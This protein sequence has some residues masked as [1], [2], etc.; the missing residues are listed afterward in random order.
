[1]NSDTDAAAELIIRTALDQDLPELQQVFREASLSNEGDAPALLAHPEYLIFTGDGIAEGRTRVIVTTVGNSQRLVGFATLARGPDGQPDVEDLFVHPQWRRRGI[2]RRLIHDLASTARREGH[3]TV[4]VI[5][6]QHAL[7][8][9]Q[10]VGFVEFGSAETAL[11]LAPHLRL[12][13]T[14]QNRAPMEVPDGARSFLASGQAYDAFMGRYSRPLAI[15]FADAVGVTAG[16][17]ALDV[18][19]GPGAL[20]GVLVDRLGPGAVSAFDPSPSFVT[21]CARRHPGVTV[22]PGRAEAMPFDEGRFDCALAQ[23]VLHFVSDPGQAAH[24]FCRVLRP[25]GLAAACV[26]DFAEGMQ[27]LRLF[28]D[29]ALDVDPEAPDEAQTLKF[30]RQGEIAELFSSAGVGD[31][32]ETTLTVRSRYVGFEDLWSGFL[33]GIGPAG[34]FC[35]SLADEQRADLRAGLFERLGSPSGAFTLT[36][37]ARC[38]YGRSP[39]P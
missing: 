2:A 35:V 8:F 22:R 14:D 26:W 21:E 39:Q 9:Y 38:A 32:T 20:T 24:E 31:I 1:M 23:L 37:K 13:L 25:G 18:G 3:A 6:N 7:E 19:C 34:S 36:A 12:D 15:A 30:G 29:A 11:G 17:S 10:A 16:Q 33:A 5:G 4:T 27:M 28:W